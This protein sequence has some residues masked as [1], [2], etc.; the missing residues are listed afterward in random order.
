MLVR[1]DLLQR[2][3]RAFT[4]GPEIRILRELFFFF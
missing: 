1:L 3:L 4:I 2:G